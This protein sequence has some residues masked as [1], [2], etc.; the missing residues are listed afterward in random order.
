LV[1]FSTNQILILLQMS[2]DPKIDLL[3]QIADVLED[4]LN[5]SSIKTRKLA[6]TKLNMIN[7]TNVDFSSYLGF[8][9]NSKEYP[10]ESRQ[11]SLNLLNSQMNSNN[12]VT[13]VDYIKIVA[14]D[15]L[16]DPIVE[17]GAVKLINNLVK[18]QGITHW[19]ELI[20]FVIAKKDSLSGL[21]ILEQIVNF[22]YV[23]LQLS[24]KINVLKYCEEHLDSENSRVR[25]TV[26]T[27]L[28]SISN[29]LDSQTTQRLIKKILK[30][31]N[32]KDDIVQLSICQFFST[33][34]DN[35]NLTDSCLD[36]FDQIWEFLL[37]CTMNNNSEIVQAASETWSLFIFEEEEDKEILERFQVILKKLIPVL[38]SLLVKTKTFED[39]M[40]TS[41]FDDDDNYGILIYFH[42]SS[43]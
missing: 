29:D 31:C 43:L 8:I 14:L 13:N 16:Q 38:V 6:Q 40:D 25:Q 30:F 37:T 18:Y 36:H 22:C 35:P 15:S 5:H 17:E 20:T 4:I 1:L 9:F 21:L 11:L 33:V 3:K 19:P 32:E 10:E 42:S 7:S 2:F 26:I 34:I 28:I 27:M 23:F 39:E 12:I 41:L 24:D